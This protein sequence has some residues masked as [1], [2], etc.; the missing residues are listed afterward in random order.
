MHVCIVLYCSM[1][2]VHILWMLLLFKEHGL[3]VASCE[4]GVYGYT[5]Y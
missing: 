2:N 5:P 4:W 3:D 1:L